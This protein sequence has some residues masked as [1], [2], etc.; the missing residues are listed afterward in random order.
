MVCIICFDIL[1]LI[2]LLKHDRYS[3]SLSLAKLVSLYPMAYSQLLKISGGITILYDMDDSQA[4][5]NSNH[6]ILS[7]LRN[8]RNRLGLLCEV[9]ASES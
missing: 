8:L 9:N 7:C 2:R 5:I 1:A 4:Y 6:S 3:C